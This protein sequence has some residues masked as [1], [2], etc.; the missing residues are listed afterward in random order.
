MHN[1]LI[2]DD[3]PDLVDDLAEML[4]WETIGIRQVFKAYSAQEA[5]D[6]IQSQPVDVVITD[7]RMPGMSGLDL[8][9][10]IRSSW[11]HIQCILLS[12]YDDFEY[13]KQG[14]QH[15]ATDYL[16]KPVEDDELMQAVKTALKQLDETW[17]AITSLQR[18]QQTFREHIP[19]LQTHLLNDL[20]QGR[21]WN[22]ERLVEKLKS[23][24]IHFQVD[25]PVV[26]LLIRIEE[27]LQQKFGKDTDL[28]DYAVFNIAE[29]IFADAFM[30]WHGKAP[31]H[32]SVIVIQPKQPLELELERAALMNQLERKAAQ[33]QHYVRTYLKGTLSLL[34]TQ[35]GLFPDELKERYQQALYY[36]FKRIDREREWL[37]IQSPK[38]PD[39]VCSEADALAS[40]YEPPTLTHFIEIGQWEQLEAKLEH[41]FHELENKWGDS[42]EH[43]LEAYYMIASALLYSIHKSKLWAADIL[44][45]DFERL[46]GGVPFHTVEQLRNWTKR[47]LEKY[48]QQ[49]HIE[50]A[51][52]RSNI[53]KQVQ[54]YVSEHLSEA[55]L[56]NIADHVYLNPSYLSK[57]YKMETG[58]GI[59]DYLYRMK[60]DRAAH[61]LRT[62]N[63]KVYEIAAS[64]GY[65]KTSYFIK[66]F[67]D[68]YGMTPQEY[69]E[70]LRL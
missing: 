69:R 23:L 30:I 7:I 1:L 27:D 58:E 65:V 41:I 11:S 36:F 31:Y 28:L 67:K 22:K 60:M 51:D 20:L 64:L 13:A 16:L 2:V 47:V 70:R 32:Y 62:T 10:E 4:P 56:Q 39:D 14:I 59:S 44:G 29:E 33:L 61:L 6:L 42:H 68:K 5:L 54:Q 40:L 37:V 45:E 34:I 3:Q 63:E 52:S 9:K 25:Q 21:K 12:G 48:K 53:V 50:I 49:M 38:Q 26:L 18:V 19:I 66:L 46:S 17:H 15:K 57:I 55:T 43:I 8:I 24:N 35:P